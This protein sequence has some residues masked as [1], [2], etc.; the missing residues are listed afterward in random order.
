VA[1]FV[2]FRDFVASWFSKVT[3]GSGDPTKGGPVLFGTTVWTASAMNEVT[4]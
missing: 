4:S 3:A 1:S 2:P